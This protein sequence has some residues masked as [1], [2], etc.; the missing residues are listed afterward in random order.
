MANELTINSLNAIEIGMLDSIDLWE[1]DA[2]RAKLLVAYI[3][4]VHD[5]ATAVRKAIVELGGK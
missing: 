4:G 2:E 1:E 5:M 3:G